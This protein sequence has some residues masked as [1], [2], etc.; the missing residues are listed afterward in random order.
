MWAQ[1]TPLISDFEVAVY[2]VLLPIAGLVLKGEGKAWRTSQSPQPIFVTGHNISAINGASHQP[3]EFARNDGYTADRPSN[4]VLVYS[5]SFRSPPCN[6]IY[7]GFRYLFLRRDAFHCQ[8]L[9]VILL[10]YFNHAN[11]S[12]G[13]FLLP[14]REFRKVYQK[15]CRHL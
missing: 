7:D 10:W 11:K 3:E 13:D 6:Y 8:R 2:N 5:L 15:S 9:F 14:L 4:V 1:S 12:I